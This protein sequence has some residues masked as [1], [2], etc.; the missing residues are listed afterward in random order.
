MER[1]DLQIKCK[2]CGTI[3]EFT[4]SDQEYFIAKGYH[5]PR[6]CKRCR[7]LRREGVIGD[8]EKRTN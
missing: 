6:R 5:K 7:R 3:F 2:E 1:K 4:V 8:V